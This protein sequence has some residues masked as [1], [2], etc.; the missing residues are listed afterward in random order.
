MGASGAIFGIFGARW[1]DLILNWG[2]TKGH[3]QSV[4]VL[5]VLTVVCFGMGFMPDLDNFAH[6]GGFVAGFF[7]GLILLTK[8][9]LTRGGKKVKQTCGQKWEHL[10]GLAGVVL[11][12]VFLWQALIVQ[13]RCSSCSSC[14]SCS[15][16][17]RPLLPRCSRAAPADVAAPLAQE[18]DFS[19]CHVCATI[20]CMDT[21]W[22]SCDEALS[23]S[24]FTTVKCAVKFSNGTKMLSCGAGKDEFPLAASQVDYVQLCGALCIGKGGGV[25]DNT[26]S[27]GGTR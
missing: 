18:M 25:A 15:Y 24:L 10:V 4:V 1:S 23:S 3:K 12:G 14:S 19:K 13:V 21:R 7:M 5:T 11:W 26:N 16:C 17:D 22:W 27:T 8:T 6:I 2:M 20:S 9:K